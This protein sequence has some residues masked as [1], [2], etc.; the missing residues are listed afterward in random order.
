MTDSGVKPG[1]LSDQ[2]LRQ[3]ARALD[4]VGDFGEVRLIK[5][6]GKLRFIQKVISEEALTAGPAT[7]AVRST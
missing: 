2:Q 5:A 1:Q 3:I 6:K 7:G 4:E